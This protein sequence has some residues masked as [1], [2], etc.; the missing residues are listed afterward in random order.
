MARIPLTDDKRHEETETFTVDLAPDTGPLP[1]FT[2]FFPG[3]VGRAVATVTIVDDDPVAVPRAILTVS[4]LSGKVRLGGRTLTAGRRAFGGAK[5]NAS[6]GSARLVATRSGRTLRS[7]TVTG[8]AVRVVTTR[9]LVLVSRRAAIRSTGIAVRGKQ[10]VMAPA[11]AGARWTIEEVRRGTRVSVRGGRVTA[12]GAT[13]RA[14][15]SRT[16]R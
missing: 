4:R 13:L 15:R 7:A 11:T 5:V 6:D 2:S 1:A 12:G 8:G 9:E 16:F 10:V 3:P 14:G